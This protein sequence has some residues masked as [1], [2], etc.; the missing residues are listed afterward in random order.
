LEKKERK[1]LA[2]QDFIFGESSQ[3]LPKVFSMWIV[4]LGSDT[5]LQAVKLDTERELSSVQ[6]LS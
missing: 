4:I 2:P 1:E 6:I 3:I 5:F